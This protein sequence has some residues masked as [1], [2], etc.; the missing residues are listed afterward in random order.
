[1]PTNR[2]LEAAIGYLGLGM[3]SD[4]WE[5]LEEID[6]A[7][8]AKPEALRVRVEVCRVLKKWKL[9]AEL[10]SHLQ[11][12]EPDEAGHAVNL[13][14]ATRRHQSIEAAEV[15]RVAALRRHHDDALIRYNLACYWC[16]M[17]RVEDSRQML[18]SACKKEKGLREVARTDTDLAILREGR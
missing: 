2:H 15:I 11:T 12:V 17:G 13:A 1:M 7:E 18:E 6:V 3:A 16:V 14:W 9:M 10:S 5:E 4:A 8:G